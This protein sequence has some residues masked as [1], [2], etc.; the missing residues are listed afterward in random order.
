MKAVK[1]IAFIL[2][3]LI[4]AAALTLIIINMVKQDE[5]TDTVNSFI[6]RQEERYA[7]SQK[8]EDEFIEDGAVIGEIYTIRSTS[9][10]SDAYLKGDPS[11]LSEEDKKTYDLAV[12]AFEEATKGCTTDYE[13]ELGIFEWIAKNITHNNSSSTLAILADEDFPVDTP[14]GVLSGKMAVC[15][16]Y[17]TTFRLLVNMAGL[18]CHIPHSESHSWDLVQLDD[19]EWYYVDLYSASNDGKSPNYSYF[20][21]NEQIANDQEDLSMCSSLPKAK[22]KK[23]LYP[24]INATDGDDFYSIPKLVKKSAKSVLKGDT[25]MISI[26]LS[27]TP[28]EKELDMSDAMTEAIQSRLQNTEPKLADWW[29]TSKWYKDESDKLVIAFFF[30]DNSY[31]NAIDLTKPEAKKMQSILD[32]VFGAGISDAFVDGE[33]DNTVKTEEYEYNG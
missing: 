19:D 24:V 21:M 5:Q 32:K 33:S 18:D 22:G 26:R 27:K 11:G 15:V 8:Q 9:A 1:A 10:I 31:S 17:A 29:I 4:A 16:G 30:T 7:E 6:D 25:S 28:T 2:V 14:Y 23:Y 3:G 13:K 20:N 12:K